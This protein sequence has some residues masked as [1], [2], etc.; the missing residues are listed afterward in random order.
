MI[1]F[2]PWRIPRR[3]AALGIFPQGEI[4]GRFLLAQTIFGDAQIA[5]AFLQGLGVAVSLRHQ[6]GV[7]VILLRIEFGDIKV[8]RAIGFKIIKRKEIISQDV[9]EKKSNQISHPNMQIHVP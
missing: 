8:H 2:S 5:F 3:L 4:V 1:T 9:I 7:L 6:F